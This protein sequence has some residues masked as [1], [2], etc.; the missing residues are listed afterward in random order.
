VVAVANLEF[1]SHSR[2]KAGLDRGRSGNPGFRPIHSSQLGANQRAAS[3]AAAP[4]PPPPPIVRGSSF[5]AP[6]ELHSLSRGGARSGPAGG[7]CGDKA[8]AAAN[9]RNKTKAWAIATTAVPSTSTKPTKTDE[10]FQRSSVPQMLA[11][12]T[13]PPSLPLT[14]NDTNRPS[15]AVETRKPL[16]PLRPFRKRGCGA[17]QLAARTEVADAHV[18]TIESEPPPDRAVTDTTEPPASNIEIRNVGVDEDKEDPKRGDVTSTTVDGVD[19]D[20]IRLR[21]ATPAVPDRVERYT[22][23]ACN[24]PL[25]I[26]RHEDAVAIPYPFRADI[27][28]VRAEIPL[29]AQDYAALAEFV[30]L[31]SEGPD[32]TS[33]AQK[34]E[35]ILRLA[36]QRECQ[37]GRGQNPKQNG[38]EDLHAEAIVEGLCERLLH[39]YER[40]WK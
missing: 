2:R 14:P 25:A 32:D 33:G 11:A 4:P 31:G 30:R 1:D 23:R 12:T 6:L 15:P 21:T 17:Q 39:E 16:R 20:R 8:E 3:H 28:P 27:V 22:R 29:T 24:L 37:Q 10:P 13:A 40:P 38:N 35:C 34:A 36:N 9:L 19:F 26:F 5:A 18:A 7:D